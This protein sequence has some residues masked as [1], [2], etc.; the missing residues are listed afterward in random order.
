LLQAHA[1]S[2]GNYPTANG[3]LGP[4]QGRQGLRLLEQPRPHRLPP[5]LALADH[6]LHGA[7]ALVAREA[8]RV[9]ASLDLLH[10]LQQHAPRRDDRAVRGAKALVRPVDDRAHALLH[11]A[12]LRVRAL[13]AGVGPGLLHLAVDHVA[14][15]AVAD[16]P[17]A[18]LDVDVHAELV[19][20]ADEQAF[21]LA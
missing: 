1:S 10:R 17:E 18:V 13:D 9:A 21:V 16:R 3:A 12:V 11:G 6:L 20:R 14:V 5:V 15:P 2:R 4:R 19:A 8:R 7:Q